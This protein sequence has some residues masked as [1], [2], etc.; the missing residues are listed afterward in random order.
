MLIQNSYTVSLKQNTNRSTNKDQKSNFISIV[1][2]VVVVVSVFFTGH[3]AALRRSNPIGS[4][5]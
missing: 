2:V 5:Q 1:F 3:V 4:I